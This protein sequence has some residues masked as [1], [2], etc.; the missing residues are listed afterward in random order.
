MVLQTD[1]Y[2]GIPD[3][4]LSHSQFFTLFELL[5]YQCLSNEF[6]MIT[7]WKLRNRVFKY[8]LRLKFFLCLVVGDV[9]ANICM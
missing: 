6:W 7:L 9:D 3:F 2:E 4:Y 8:H 1:G 5:V